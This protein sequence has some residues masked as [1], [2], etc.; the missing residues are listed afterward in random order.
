MM[1]TQAAWRLRISACATSSAWSSVPT[2]VTTTIRSL[3]RIEGR[4]DA[5]T[6][7]MSRRCPPHLGILRRAGCYHLPWF[8]ERI[9]RRIFV[10]AKRLRRGRLR[11]R[12]HAEVHSPRKKG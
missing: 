10:G 12:L 9:E 5:S 2:E 8:F 4:F 6:G 7:E 11:E 3:G 1:L